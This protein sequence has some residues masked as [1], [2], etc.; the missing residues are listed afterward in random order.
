L[1]RRLGQARQHHFDK[2]SEFDRIDEGTA[3][4][5]VCHA[6]DQKADCRRRHK[7]PLDRLPHDPSATI[8]AFPVH[9]IGKDFEC[10]RHRWFALCQPTRC[11]PS[12]EVCAGRRDPA[13]GGARVRLDAAIRRRS[14][15]PCRHSSGSRSLPILPNRVRS[16]N[17]DLPSSSPDPERDAVVR[18]SS[19]VARK[20]YRALFE[21]R[22]TDN[23]L[24]QESV[25]AHSEV[26]DP[27]RRD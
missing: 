2:V 14:L 9:P 24:R 1:P 11:E 23:A 15:S 13:A 12:G 22:A 4:H 19:L 26:G 18:G 25:Y 5:K 17:R 27:V 3:W 8:L 21:L 10:K 16:A 6:P 20:T 7:H